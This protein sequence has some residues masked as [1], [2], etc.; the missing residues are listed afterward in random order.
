M[1]AGTGIRPST[2]V[3]DLD[4][5]RHNVTTLRGNDGAEV[6]AVVKADAYGHGAVAVAKA[7]CEAG[8]TWLAVAL[9]EEARVLREAG[10]RVPM[11]LLS[12]PPVAAAGAVCD[13]QLTP[14]VYSPAFIDALN[15]EAKARNIN[16]SVHLKLDT[17]MG[18]VGVSE[19][20]L[21]AVLSRLADATGL[22]VEGVGTHLARS[23]ETDPAGKAETLR[24]LTLFA[25]LLP[26][27][28]E[29]GFTPRFL[30]A[31]NTAAALQ[32]PAS[33]A[34]TW[35]GGNPQTLLRCGIGVYGLSPSGELDALTNG[36]RPALSVWSAVSFV[37]QVTAGTPVSYGHRWHAPANGFLATVPIGYADGVPRRLTNRAS[38]IVNGRRLPVVGTITMDQLMVWSGETPVTV[39]D[40]VMLIGTS[41]TESIRVEQWAQT[42][43]TIT[44]ELTSQLTARLPRS[45]DGISPLEAETKTL[46]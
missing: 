45:Y 19:H 4:A 11:L 25:A 9:V 30:H 36:L 29:A 37:K 27:V 21:G 23:D 41:G 10:I 32:H 33:R 15:S 24:Q 14:F 35:S 2:C 43:D 13:L 16:V 20:G 39:H 34:L 26:Q 42:L 44:Y 6:C 40:P 31:A 28:I 5:I 12:E 38:V 1:M 8:A 3:V 7:A 46:R 18:R 22:S 17:G